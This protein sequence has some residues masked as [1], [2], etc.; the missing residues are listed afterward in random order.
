MAL[1]FIEGF[2]DLSGWTLANSPT[3]P[4]GRNGNCLQLAS[5]TAATAEWPI[6]GAVQDSTY[7]LGVAMKI[8]GSPVAPSS[9]SPVIQL[10]DPPYN[11]VQH[12]ITFAS[13]GQI[14]VYQ[15]AIQLGVSAT[16]AYPTGTWFYLEAQIFV[17]DATGT[18]TLRVNGTTVLT[19]TAKDTKASTTSA[20]VGKITLNNVPGATNTQYDDL[21]LMTGTG[22]SFQGDS[23]VEVLYPN[24]DGST[25]A[26]TNSAG[27]STSNWSFVDENPIDTSDYVASA[28]TGQD[29]LY[30]LTDLISTAQ[31]ILAVQP[32]VYAAKTDTTAR[33]VKLLTRRTATTAQAAQNLDNVSAFTLYN[34]LTTDPDTSGAWTPAN[35]NALQVGVEAA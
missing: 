11:S 34:V 6:P 4:A 2:E 19:L 30:T 29:D 8:T 24:G 13:S 17:N 28:T 5:A 21:Y 12:M 23:R 26:W 25:N 16:G 27:N 10:W 31:S 14:A 32:T 35:V 3:N 1:R 9:G 7:T 15:G 22:D 20:L 33:Q 18:V